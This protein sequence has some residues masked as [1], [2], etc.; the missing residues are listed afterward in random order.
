MNRLGLLRG[1]LLC[2][3]RGWGD[4]SSRLGLLRLGPRS[5][6]KARPD[7][8]SVAGTYTASARSNASRSA[9]LPGARPA[10]TAC[11][12]KAGL[13]ACLASE[14]PVLTCLTYSALSPKSGL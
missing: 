10:E 12:A 1:R 9:C 3:L 14:C 2:R 6:R 11:P 13:R 4:W 5:R 8:P 7:A